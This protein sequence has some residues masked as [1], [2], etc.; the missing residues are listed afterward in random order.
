[1]GGGGVGRGKIRARIGMLYFKERIVQAIFYFYP[2]SHS[3][4]VPKISTQIRVKGLSHWYN[5]FF[6]TPDL[7]ALF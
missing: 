1:M 5:Y 2:T 3:K 6:V 7:N 4:R